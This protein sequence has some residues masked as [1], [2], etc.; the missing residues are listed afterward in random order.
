VDGMRM[1]GCCEPGGLHGVRGRPQ[2]VRSHVSDSGCLCGRSGRRSGSG[3]ADGT[4]CA[5]GDEAPADLP[6]RVE[7]TRPKA[8]AR[9]MASRGRSSVEAS[10]SNSG[11]TC[12][13]QSAAHIATSRRA[14]SLSAWG[15]VIAAPFH[16]RGCANAGR[17]TCPLHQWRIV[18]RDRR[19]ERSQR[20]SASRRC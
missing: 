8:R 16:T 14:A 10:A 9:A 5:D 2:G 13:A 6:S 15:E 12:S 1:V 7:V 3:R 17:L 20:V 4:G 11:R 18:Q 19:G